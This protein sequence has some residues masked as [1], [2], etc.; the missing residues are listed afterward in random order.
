LLLLLLRRRLRQRLRSLGG[1]HV[2][3]G[4]LADFQAALRLAE[5][6]VRESAIPKGRAQGAAYMVHT[7]KDIKKA[8][9]RHAMH[10][11]ANVIHSLKYHALSW[12]KQE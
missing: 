8:G 3:K 6:K 4:N 2:I 7:L 11:F 5:Q 1:S 12:A 10:N 9:Q